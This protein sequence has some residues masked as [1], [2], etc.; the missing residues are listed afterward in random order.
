MSILP[1]EILHL[2]ITM[3]VVRF[4]VVGLLSVSPF[5][6]RFLSV[7]PLMTRSL[8]RRLLAMRPFMWCDLPFG[9]STL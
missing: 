7:M 6:M 5:P 2:L 9:D 3:V 4:I 8:I 1:L